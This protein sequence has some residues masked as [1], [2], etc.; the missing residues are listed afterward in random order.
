MHCAQV[1]IITQ[2]FHVQLKQRQAHQIVKLLTEIQTESVFRRFSE[3]VE[4]EPRLVS[5]TKSVT[6][7]RDRTRCV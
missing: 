6:E 2:T 1:A 5:R 7:P 3:P 4:D